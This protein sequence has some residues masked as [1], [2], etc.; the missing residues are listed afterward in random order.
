MKKYIKYLVFSFLF[1]CLIGGIKVSAKSSLSSSFEISVGKE[2]S[3]PVIYT[4]EEDN[5]VI[6]ERVNFSVTLVGKEETA[7]SFRW[8][9]TLCY[10]LSGKAE[11]CEIDYTGKDQEDSNDILSNQ[12][13]DYTFYDSDMD[14]YSEDLTFEYV[15]FN[16]KLIC[17]EEGCNDEY[18][19][20]ELYFDSTNIKYDY[21][22]DITQSIKSKTINDKTYIAPSIYSNDGYYS[23]FQST[24]VNNSTSTLIKENAP[25]YKF[26]V[27]ACGY[28][29]DENECTKKEY[30][31]LSSSSGSVSIT[32]YIGSFT[33]P[34]ILENLI[35]E[36]RSI[37]YEYAVYTTKLEC[38]ENCSDRRVVASLTLSE[39]TFYFKYSLPQVNE[40]KTIINSSV[41]EVIYVKNSDVTISVSDDLVGLDE[42]S[43][44][45]EIIK[46]YSGYCNQGY[47]YTYSY[48][49]DVKFTIGD[50]LNGGYCMRYSVS[51]NIGNTYT[52]NY[53]IFY[54]DNSGPNMSLDNAYDSSKYYN[55]ISLNPTFTDY[56]EVGE[57]Y[58]LWSK[59]VVGE[60]D[61]LKIKSDGQVFSNEINSDNLSDGS[62][63]LYIL[64]YDALNNYKYY[65]LGLFNI[66]KTPLSV[67]DLSFSLIGDNSSYSNTNK[68]KVYVSEM[69]EE[70]QFKCGFL[71]KENVIINDLNLTCLNNKEISYP[72][73]LEGEYSFYVYVRDRANNYNM[74]EIVS[75]LLIDTLS[76]RV[77]ASILYD[78]DEYHVNN[79][80]KLVVNDING[81]NDL[82]YGWFK[83]SKSN[84]TSLDLV[85]SYDSGGVIGYPSDYY[86][87][88]K[89]YYKAIDNLGNETF[90]SVEKIFKI[91]TDIVSI[92]LV[93]EETIKLIK[94]E[95]YEELGARAFK[96]NL[97][98]GGRYSD[99]VV[100]GTVDTS[101]VGK[102][103][104]T[105]SSGE[106]NFKVSV[107]R[108]I[109]VYDNTPY[110]ITIVS[111]FVIGSVLLVFR[112]FIKRKRT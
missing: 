73:F 99:V 52:S 87:E 22:F 23:Y 51:D 59:S 11:V 47:T 4:L 96:G 94:H 48:S 10:K 76:P 18:V 49:S 92:K 16:N 71:N 110:I 89:L 54:F 106:G 62:Y 95:K 34:N 103:Y 86:G 42:S 93:G 2:N 80:I 38:V 102:Y 61:Y 70:E 8:E 1:L 81:F 53:Y 88:Y 30:T 46:P 98:T 7:R 78:D 39:N 68:V 9:H 50:G 45:Y 57:K 79:E 63:Y 26:I 43:L 67:S 41:D 82:K 12:T 100:E 112:L 109:I 104:I 66:D 20:D 6:K 55:N 3:L 77:N 72:S 35:Y 27:E 44:K 84:I 108:E 56:V 69:D 60:D 75:G 29:R 91:D 111:L 97:L 31:N 25:S 107:T 85:N 24:F 14:Y 32:P 21:S 28:P 74:V 17:L 58:Y 40:N 90:A 13:Y 15:R 83:S 5:G 33:Y 19:L 37:Q 36:D 64:V 101:K 65:D 105:Y